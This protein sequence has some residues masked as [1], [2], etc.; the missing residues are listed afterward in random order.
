M[1]S[2]THC[3]SF[4]Y[5]CDLYNDLYNDCN[6]SISTNL[7]LSLFSD[8][9]QTGASSE[10]YDKFS[11]RYHISIIFK[12]LWRLPMHQNAMVRFST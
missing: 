5:N 1:Y 4:F 10:F 7:S 12:S 9:E 3:P 2:S 11:I 6:T 8:V